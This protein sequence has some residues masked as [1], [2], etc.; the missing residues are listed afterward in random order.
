MNAFIQIS[1]T[2]LMSVMLL[3]VAT[4]VVH[5][6]TAWI[7]GGPEGEARLKAFEDRFKRAG[8]SPRTG[9]ANISGLR[10][11]QAKLPQQAGART[12]NRRQVQAGRSREGVVTEGE[13]RKKAFHSVVDG[14][15]PL[16]PKEIV[17]LHSLFN[18]TQ[19]A[20]GTIPGVPPKPVSRTLNVDLSP[21]AIP[22]V[23]RLYSGFITTVVIV[24]STGTAWPIEYIDL[25]N[26]KAFNIQWNQKDNILMIQAVTIAKIANLMVKLRGLPTPVMLTLVPDQKAID[27]RVDLRI[28]GIGPDTKKMPKTDGLPASASNVLLDIINGVTP[29]GAKLLKVSGANCQAWYF[30]NKLYV[31]TRFKL[32]SPGWLASMTSADG[33]HAYELQRTPFVLLTQHGKTVSMRITGFQD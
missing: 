12:T 23:V 14:A 20:A 4:H 15:L 16:S 28:P 3:L 13:V 10:A 5:A 29:A 18:A 33:T 21:G 6:D 11:L 19:R 25:G 22:P 2:M 17:Q 7:T 26:P 30:K 1:K 27:Y 31:R 8:R 9:N 24:D 32:L